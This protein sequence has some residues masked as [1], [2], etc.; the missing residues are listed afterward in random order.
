M[1][2]RRERINIVQS[3]WSEDVLEDKA[4]NPLY[5]ESL[6]QGYSQRTKDNLVCDSTAVCSLDI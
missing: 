2:S 1:G 4:V 6:Y 3:G 5:E